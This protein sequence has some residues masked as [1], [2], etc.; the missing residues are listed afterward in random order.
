[1]TFVLK[2]K[3]RLDKI[4]QFYIKMRNPPIIKNLFLYFYSLIL[5]FDLTLNPIKYFSIS[6]TTLLV[7]IPSI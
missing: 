7:A 1:M 4:E 5:S 6:L 2:F 3:I